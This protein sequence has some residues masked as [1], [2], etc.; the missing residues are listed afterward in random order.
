VIEKFAQALAKKQIGIR[1][2]LSSVGCET[3][4]VKKYIDAL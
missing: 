2:F 3:H 4:I 1:I